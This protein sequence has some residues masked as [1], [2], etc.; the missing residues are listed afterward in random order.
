MAEVVRYVNTASAG[1]DG[2]TNN[3]AGATAAYASLNAWEAAEQTDLDTA[4]NWMHVYCS[5]GSGTAADAVATL[6]SG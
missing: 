2:T 6:I 3:E 1:G 5:T 4:N